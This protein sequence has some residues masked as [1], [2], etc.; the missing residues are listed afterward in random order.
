MSICNHIKTLD[1]RHFS[2]YLLVLQRVKEP[3]L[4]L[5]F[6]CINNCILSTTNIVLSSYR[7]MSI[8]DRSFPIIRLSIED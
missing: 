3:C 5:L 1:Y 8:V 4:L 7:N 2:N 6:K